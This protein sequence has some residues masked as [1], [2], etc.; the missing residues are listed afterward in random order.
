MARMLSKALP[1]AVPPPP[2]EWIFWMGL[3]TVSVSLGLTEFQAH[4]NGAGNWRRPGPRFSP[5]SQRRATDPPPLRGGV[6]LLYLNR[7]TRNIV[8]ESVRLDDRRRPLQRIG[9]LDQPR[10]DLLRG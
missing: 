4:G 10:R 2:S 3:A 9:R 1:I 5:A 7:N 6:K 8:A